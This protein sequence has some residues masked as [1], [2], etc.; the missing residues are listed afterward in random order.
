MTDSFGLYDELGLPYLEH[1][2]QRFT[3]PMMCEHGPFF[4][5]EII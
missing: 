4:W 3:N 5:M 2:L 1:P